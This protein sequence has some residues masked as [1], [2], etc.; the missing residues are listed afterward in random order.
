MLMPTT[1]TDMLPMLTLDTV[2]T[3][4]DTPGMVVTDISARGPLMPS[5]R[6]MPLPPLRLP[7][8]LMP[9]TDTDMLPMPT[10]DTV[11]TDTDTPG[12]VVTDLS[13]R[14]PLMPM[15]MPTTAM[16]AMATDTEATDIGMVDTGPDTSMVKRNFINNAMCARVLD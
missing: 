8:M 10:L 14:G 12:M 9:T 2:P 16:E 3:D 4:T 15:P 5:P 6:L 1:D 13:A 11:P 7:L